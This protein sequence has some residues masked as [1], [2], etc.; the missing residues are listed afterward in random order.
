MTDLVQHVDDWVGFALRR[1]PGWEVRVTNG[2]ISVVQDPSGLVNAIIW[3]LLLP[4]PLPPL[5][6]ARQ[7]ISLW[8]SGKRTVRAWRAGDEPLVL[9]T[10]FQQGGRLLSG[11][12]S[13]TAQQGTGLIAGFE[14]PHEQAEAMAPV[15]HDVVSSFQPVP[16][17]P[18]LLFRDPSEGAFTALYP[19]GW[20]V[21]GGVN[22]TNAFG[23]GIPYFQVTDGTF[24]ADNWPTSFSFVEGWFETPGQQRLA[25]MTAP[26]F[27][28]QWL[29]GWLQRQRGA[30]KVERVTDRPDA[31]PSLALELAKAG[32]SPASCDLSAATLQ[33]IQLRDGRELRHRIG[34]V[35]QR[36]REGGGI[37]SMGSGSWSAAITSSASG[38]AEQFDRIEPVLTGVLDSFQKD[39]R[40]E[41]AELARMQQASARLQ[42]D[43]NAR[44]RQIS[45][46]LHETTDI[47]NSTFWQRQV[48]QDHVAHHWSNAML[49]RTD[50]I[51]SSGTTYSVPNDFDQVWRD[52]QGNFIGTGWLVNPDPTW[53][54]LEFVDR[55]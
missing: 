37:W 31:V 10:E 13:I 39:Q 54:K 7:L 35:V 52:P 45:Q 25:Y 11:L 32:I 20:R 18:R 42:Q 6:I 23:A 8:S 17:M 55:R 41:E 21:N 50:V 16:S 29:P 47:I 30:L 34:V 22:R 15:L 27:A 12:Y 19:Q 2:I 26:E 49:G 44:L 33:L 36:P 1:P 14:T 3:P 38:P 24:A 48:V 40:W 4:Q 51:D 53:E 9:R 43:T 5:E 46:T 28:L